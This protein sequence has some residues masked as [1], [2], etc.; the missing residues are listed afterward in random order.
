MQYY[1]EEIENIIGLLTNPKKSFISTRKA[2]AISRDKLPYKY[3]HKTVEYCRKCRIPRGTCSCGRERRKVHGYIRPVRDYEL[4]SEGLSLTSQKCQQAITHEHEGLRIGSRVCHKHVCTQCKREY[5][6]THTIKAGMGHYSHLC[7]TCNEPIQ[8]D[9]K[10]VSEANDIGHNSNVRESMVTSGTSTLSTNAGTAGVD[11]SN[12]PVT[13]VAQTT[14]YT[15]D[16]DMSDATIKETGWDLSR[17][18]ERPNLVSSFLWTTESPRFMFTLPVPKG[19]ITTVLSR[20]PFSAFQ[21]WRGDILLRIQVAGAPLYQGLLAATFIPLVDFS[22]QARFELNLPALTINP[23]VYLYANTNTSAE[24]RIPYKH[25]QAYLSTTFPNDITGQLGFIKI[26][27]VNQIAAAGTFPGVT[28]SVFSIFENSEFKVPVI[29]SR[30]NPIQYAQDNTLFSEAELLG[31]LLGSG[32]GGLVGTGIT[33]LKD[34]ALGL[35][36]GT[37]TSNIVPQEVSRASSSSRR[38]VKNVTHTQNMTDIVQQASSSAMPTNFLGDVLDMASS[39][40]G[41]DNPTIPVPDPSVV[42]RGNGPTNYSEGPEFIEKLS[43]YPSSMNV[44]TAE[45]FGTITDEMDLDYLKRRYSYLTTFR[46]STGDGPNQVL[47]SIPMS[48]VIIPQATVGRIVRAPVPFLSYLG[49]PFRYWTGTMV[50]KLQVIASVAHT[51][52]IYVAF[53]YGVYEEP[54]TLLD[55]SSQYGVVYEVTQGSNEF[56]FRVPYISTTPYKLVYN[57]NYDETNTMGYINIVVLNTLIAPLSVAQSIEYNLFI[58]GGPDFTY[59]VLSSSNNFVPVRTLLGQDSSYNAINLSTSRL[60]L[61]NDAE[62]FKYIYDNQ[63]LPVSTNSLYSEADATGLDDS[64]APTNIGTTVTDTNVDVQVTSPQSRDLTVDSHFGMMSRSIRDLLK[65]YQYCETLRLSPIGA[66]NFQPCSV[67]MFFP[68]KYL[69]PVSVMPSSSIYPSLLDVPQYRSA[70]LLTW[71]ASMFRLWRGP[72]RFKLVATGLQPNQSLRV[73]YHPYYSDN[74]FSVDQIATLASQSSPLSMFGS[75][76]PSIMVIDPS[77]Q[78][79]LLANSPVTM[80]MATS[81]LTTVEF[82]LPFNT[83]YSSLLTGRGVPDTGL[84]AGYTQETCNIGSLLVT[85]F[86]PA[87]VDSNPQVHGIDVYMAIGDETRLGVLYNVP[88]IYNSSYVLGDVSKPTLITVFPSQYTV[89]TEQ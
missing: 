44:V 24:L 15:D 19:L 22:T 64:T 73:F 47:M 32:L 77:V 12:R 57:G 21:Y 25:F 84:T 29:S 56:E 60:K 18:M 50:Y 34:T 38:K 33:A 63:L 85:V 31:G 78:S 67:A 49:L 17:I 55:A 7:G 70:G 8:I 62:A 9:T 5:F 37:G 76:D 16:H 23:T 46:Q 79:T 58:A 51:T 65:K 81:P 88:E 43:V 14:G 39:M 48:P 83:R 36:R 27:W 3:V 59:E 53:N 66:A 52:K 1:D 6:H 69:T 40:F 86:P 74:K 13:S 71:A 68:S 87:P 45:T 2:Q 41:L 54:T 42:I 28:V 89:P 11:M 35:L 4:F 30:I 82:E 26:Y 20:I 61:T 75:V 10:L 80:A 72:L